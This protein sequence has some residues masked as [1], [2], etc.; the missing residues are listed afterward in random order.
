MQTL[1]RSDN[2]CCVEDRNFGKQKLTTQPTME[3]NRKAV[4]VVTMDV[5]NCQEISRNRYGHD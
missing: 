5:C 4:I 2:V 1:G 3:G